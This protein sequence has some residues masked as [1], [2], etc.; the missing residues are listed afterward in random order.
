VLSWVQICWCRLHEALVSLMVVGH[1]APIISLEN[2]VRHSCGGK[3]GRTAS[4][5][6]VVVGW[7]AL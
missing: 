7:G 4:R 3:P 6:G 5:V 1:K 2:E